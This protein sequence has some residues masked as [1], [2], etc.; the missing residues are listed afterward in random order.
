MFIVLNDKAVISLCS[1]GTSCIVFVRYKMTASSSGTG[2]TEIETTSLEDPAL[3]SLTRILSLAVL[4]P[5][6]VDYVLFIDS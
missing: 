1:V 3:L 4:V 2:V 5:G 6:M